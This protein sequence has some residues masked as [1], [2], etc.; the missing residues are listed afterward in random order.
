MLVLSRRTSEKILLPS[1]D[2]TVQVVSIRPGQVRIGIEAPPN[3]QVLRAEIAHQYPPSAGLPPV[4]PSN[5]ISPELA[6]QF[7]AAHAGVAMLRR[8]IAAGLTD[9]IR[10]T[11]DRLDQELTRLEEKL[12][13]GPT[14]SEAMTET[15]PMIAN[16]SRRGALA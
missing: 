1:L 11:L 6:N 14:P 15:L 9:D 3:V 12:Q 16:G 8:Q 4:V 7:Q 13:G 10:A 5:I 2:V